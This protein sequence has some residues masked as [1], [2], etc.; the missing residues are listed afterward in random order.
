MRRSANNSKRLRFKG[1]RIRVGLN[2]REGV[3]EMCGKVG[4]KT[5]MRHEY[6][7]PVN[8]LAN[9]IEL[10]ARCHAIEQNRSRGR[11]DDLA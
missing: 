11:R 4:G 5:D 6:Y 7:D 2:P 9:T 10:C 8:P 1:K 3:C